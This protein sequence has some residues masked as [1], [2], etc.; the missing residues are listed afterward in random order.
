MPKYLIRI[1]SENIYDTVIKADNVKQASDLA[2]NAL[3]DGNPEIEFE[4]SHNDLRIFEVKEIK[5]DT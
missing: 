2:Y 1:K 5:N 4:E 3:C